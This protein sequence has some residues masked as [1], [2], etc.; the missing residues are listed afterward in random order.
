MLNNTRT[1]IVVAICL[2]AFLPSGV[3]V[4]PGFYRDGVSLVNWAGRTLRHLDIPVRRV[5]G[6]RWDAKTRNLYLV[7][8]CVGDGTACT[9]DGGFGVPLWIV[10]LPGGLNIAD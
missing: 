10:S 9:E 7:R 8:E 3:A 4:V 6:V 2:A 1:S 5:E